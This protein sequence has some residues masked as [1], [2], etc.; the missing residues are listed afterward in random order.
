MIETKE[1]FEEML[2]ELKMRLEKANE[3]LKQCPEGSLV[4]Y[5]RGGRKTFFQVTNVNEARQRKGITRNIQLVKALT[6]KVY[7]QEEIGILEKDVQALVGFLSKYEE[8]VFSNIHKNVPERFKILGENILIEKRDAWENEPYRISDYKPEMRRHLTSSGQKVRSKS[9]IIIAEKLHEYGIPFRYEQIL[10]I[11][12]REFAPDFTIRS[13]S[14]KIF[15]WEHF[16]MTHDENYINYN[17]WKQGQY[18]QAGIVPWDN[19]IVTYDS[20]DGILNIPLIESEI[21]YRLLKG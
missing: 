6:E 9:E 20:E 13:S 21:I 2:S 17:R 8:P 7:L 19:L 3:R 4:Q 15:Y 10:T 12:G 16:G 14:G 18:E 5:N 11:G 1:Y